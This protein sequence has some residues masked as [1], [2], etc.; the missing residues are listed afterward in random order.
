[1]HS[2]DCRGDG[3]RSLASIIPA[4]LHLTLIPSGFSLLLS[5]CLSDGA[6]VKMTY[7]CFV[8]FVVLTGIG[9][10]GESESQDDGREIVVHWFPQ[11]HSD[12]G[13]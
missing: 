7:P 1:M 10:P 12:C 13:K 5:V 6:A 8:G 2:G 9:E 4:C 11:L 3:E